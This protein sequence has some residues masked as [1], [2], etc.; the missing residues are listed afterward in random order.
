MLKDQTQFEPLADTGKVEIGVNYDDVVYTS[1]PAVV[2]EYWTTEGPNVTKIKQV[3][4][5]T[6]ATSLHSQQGTNDFETAKILP[7]TIDYKPE[8]SQVEFTKTVAAKEHIQRE[9]S[10][11]EMPTIFPAKINYEADIGKTKPGKINLH[12]WSTQVE[13]NKSTV[14]KIDVF[15]EESLSEIA[16]TLPGKVDFK[17]YESHVPVS[18]DLPGFTD[19]KK[20]ENVSEGINILPA[21]ITHENGEVAQTLVGR[22]DSKIDDNQNV[23]NVDLPGITQGYLVDD[24]TTLP[25]KTDF[26]SYEIQ[27]EVA[28]TL[29][30]KIEDQ[31]EIT[32]TLTAFGYTSVTNN[33]KKTETSQN[34]VSN[35]P[36]PGK[37]NLGLWQS[38][39]ETN[40]TFVGKTD[41]RKSKEA[42]MTKALSGRPNVVNRERQ[43]V[44]ETETVQGPN[45]PNRRE[46]KVEIGKT[47]MSS[48][49]DAHTLPGKIE[50]D[51][52]ENHAKV[53]KPALGLV[54]FSSNETQDAIIRT[55]PESVN[56]S[57]ASSQAEVATKIDFN[58]SENQVEEHKILIGNVNFDTEFVNNESKTEISE[59][60]HDNI[61]FSSTENQTESI[62]PF[63]AQN[64]VEKVGKLD[65]KAWEHQVEENKTLV[66]KIDVV[67]GEHL[68]EIAKTLLPGKIEFV[69]N[70][71]HVGEPKTFQASI[72]SKIEENKVEITEIEGDAEADDNK[73]EIAKILPGAIQID[74]IKHTP[75]FKRL[76]SQ[77]NKVLGNETAQGGND[78]KN[79][80][81][82]VNIPIDSNPVSPGLS[83][84]ELEE[85]PAVEVKT[86]TN[87]VIG[88]IKRKLFFITNKS[89]VQDS[90]NTPMNTPVPVE[91]KGDYDYDKRVDELQTKSY[92]ISDIGLKTHEA[93]TFSSF[94]STATENTYEITAETI[95]ESY[96]YSTDDDKIYSATKYK[97]NSDSNIVQNKVPKSDRSE[98]NFITSPSD[99]KE[100]LHD[101]ESNFNRNVTNQNGFNFDIPRAG[102]ALTRSAYGADDFKRSTEELKRAKS[103]AELDLGDVVQG[104]V[105]R[106]VGRIKS[107][108]FSRRESVKTEIN[109]KEMPRKMSVLEK[110]ALFEVSFNNYS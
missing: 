44:G 17:T 30:G 12:I 76:N 21:R 3:T 47:S 26:K 63:L 97:L 103:L 37:I 25:A 108:D 58:S 70:E 101:F 18:S 43:Q 95:E 7:G 105:K 40:K 48:Y 59:T 65:L 66:D 51:F 14:D 106:I 54:D 79:N 28:T 83:D 27:T 60:V 84:P 24:T 49:G 2:T 67:K 77:E 96:T 33:T 56:Y 50:F 87:S 57:I 110:I 72:D 69:T 36:K 98:H 1:E 93:K 92:S 68:E 19:L 45:V 55:L 8:E 41:I 80:V 20:E 5:V 13:M 94:T 35:K 82:K 91:S 107:V 104:Q 39:V 31:T 64:S 61:Y 78:P 23:V 42:E 4:T 34:V 52:T 22:I 75:L 99:Y 16:Q 38:Q 90:T 74:P 9:P 81:Y 71:S 109:I 10:V 102:N 62:P 32:K 86:N 73:V 100:D 29:P 46:Y 11:I 53:A 6:E 88:S 85:D 89:N 15:K